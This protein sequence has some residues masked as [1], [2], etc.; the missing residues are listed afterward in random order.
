MNGR[1]ISF[2]FGTITLG[3]NDYKITLQ[4]KLAQVALIN[5]TIR[6]IYVGKAG[7]EITVSGKLPADD[8]SALY[9]AASPLIA[10]ADTLTVDGISFTSAMLDKLVIT[11]S[12]SDGFAKYDLSFH[13]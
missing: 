3:V 4:D 5:G 10:T 2:T 8:C 7:A 6:N 13:I 12:A 11:P 9:T 1:K